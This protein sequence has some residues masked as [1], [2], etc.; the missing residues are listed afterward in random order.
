MVKANILHQRDVL[1]F[2][3]TKKIKIHLSNRKFLNFSLSGST[4][5]RLYQI[6]SLPALTIEV[7]HLYE[8]LHSSQLSQEHYTLSIVHPLLP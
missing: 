5:P 3:I 4:S 2:Y 1:P 6:L 8:G 7:L